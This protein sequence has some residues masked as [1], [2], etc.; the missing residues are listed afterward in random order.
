MPICGNSQK[1]NLSSRKQ[2]S[3]HL[4][5]D[6][7]NGNIIYSSLV[8]CDYRTDGLSHFSNE[9]VSLLEDLATQ[10]E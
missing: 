7:D 8:M 5:E 4:P 6:L 9:Y 1:H 2:F 3:C 10:Q